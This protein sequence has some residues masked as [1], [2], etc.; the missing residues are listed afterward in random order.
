MLPSPLQLPHEPGRGLEV[1]FGVERLR[2]AAELLLHLQVRPPLPLIRIA[3]LLHARRECRAGG[4]EADLDVVAIL[5]R[6]Q[7]RAV[8]ERGP[9]VSQRA[10]ARLQRE[11][12]GRRQRFGLPA[13]LMQA[14]ERVLLQLRPVLELLLLHVFETRDHA[15]EPFGRRRIR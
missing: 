7:G 14:L 12:L 1:L 9:S 8:L 5:L 13:E 3:Q 4:F 11:L 15:L 10:V 6:R 2:G